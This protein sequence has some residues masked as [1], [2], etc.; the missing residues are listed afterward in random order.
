V[1]WFRSDLNY[2]FAE[3]LSGGEQIFI[4]GREVQLAELENLQAGDLVTYEVR[5]D[6][7]GPRPRAVALQLL[8]PTEKTA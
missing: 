2:G 6:P 3:S 1:V 5:T 8:E 7:Y 4:P